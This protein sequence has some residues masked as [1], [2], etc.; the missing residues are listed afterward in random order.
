MSHLL[1]RLGGLAC[2]LCLAGGASAATPHHPALAP[3]YTVTGVVT[4]VGSSSVTI[5][6]S[7]RRVGVIN[8]MTAAAGAI[9][10]ED[11][12]YVWAGGHARAGAASVGARGPGYNG[13]R[14]GFDCSGSVAA[15]LVAGGLWPAGGGVPSELGVIDQL[16]AEHLIARG[17]GASPSAVTLYDE[18]GVHIFMNIDGRFFGTSD[19]AGG[20]S[21]KGG[22]GWL[23]DGA[24]D[25]YIRAFHQY[26]VVASALRDS[27]A[28]SHSYTVAAG[29]P[30]LIAGVAAG[31]RVRVSLR[32]GRSG[33]LALISLAY[34]GARS[35][36]GTVAAI[37]AGGSSFAVLTPGGQT[38]TYSPTE[39]A[40]TQSLALGDQVLVT[41][42]AR[43]RV[44][45]ARSVTVTAAPTVLQAAGTVTATASDGSSLTVAPASG[46]PLTFSTA[47]APALLHGIQLGEQ[48]QVAYIAVGP[49]LIA[50]SV[51]PAAPPPE[52][53]APGI[54]VPVS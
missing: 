47:A 31:D 22:P 18:P 21:R 42:I 49:T 30:S 3:T 9:T 35:A 14:L 37:A 51:T 29:D 39:P 38:L 40:L 44:L 54:P 25:A 43:G 36:R 20:G 33:T 48:V 6:T 8:A 13:R 2:V 7:G 32:S 12:P 46:A 23:D 15:V 26:H 19:G 41:Y 28:Y 34:P 45:T 24:P 50:Q 1:A 16:L 17:P 10:R 5:A 27:P 4:A 53:P 52:V 11:Y